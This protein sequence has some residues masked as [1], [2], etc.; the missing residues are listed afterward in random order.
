MNAS[1]RDEAA[2][3]L[4]AGLHVL[5]PREDGSKA[6]MSVN[7][8]WDTFKTEQPT[9]DQC[10]QWWGQSK[11]LGV[12]AAAGVECMDFDDL[13]AYREFK[14][15]A[16]ETNLDELVERIEQGYCD[17]TPGGGVR[18]LWRCPLANRSHNA[19]LARR[20]KRGDEKS[21]ERD[22]VKVLIELPDYAIVA[23]TGPEVHPAGKPYVRR[24]GGFDSVQEISVSERDALVELARSFDEMPAH[25][26]QPPDGPMA[27]TGTGRPGDEFNAR[28]SWSEILSGWKVSHSKGDTTYWTRPG[29]DWGVSASTN[30]AGTDLL[31]C[32]ST[33]TP[34]DPDRSYSKFSAYALL[35]HDGDFSAAAGKLAAD[36]YG[37]P[38]GVTV[39]T[40]PSL[41][42]VSFEKVE[43]AHYKMYAPGADTT[44]T[45]E[46]LRQDR[47]GL[48]CD[49]TV[50]CT[51][52]ATR[53][54][55][56]V[57]Y[58]GRY[59]LSSVT[60]RRTQAGYLGDMTDA[61]AV[62]WT[63]LL[64][65]LSRRV[66]K[67]ENAAPTYTLMHEIEIP[68][69]DLAQE[70]LGLRL[71]YG[72]PMILFGDGGTVK[73]YTALYIAGILALRGLSVAYYDWEL[74]GGEHR[75]RLRALFGDDN[76]PR[77]YYHRASRPLRDEAPA[78]KQMVR[79]CG[80]EYAVFD[81]MGFACAGPAE[82]HEA[83]KGYHEGLRSLGE[84]G[85]LHIAHTVK[86]LE[87]GSDRKPFGSA[88]WH[89]MARGTWNIK[90]GERDPDSA[91]LSLG[92]YNR[93]PLPDSSIAHPLELRF[94]FGPGSR[95]GAPNSVQVKT[96]DPGTDGKLRGE[97][98]TPTRV[99]HE[100]A[101]GP[102]M[103]VDLQENLP[104]VS[105]EALKKTLQRLR[106]DGKLEVVENDNRQQAYAL[107]G[108]EILV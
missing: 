85:S 21:H 82:T 15:W 16:A 43:D 84:I 32:W 23:P 101:G 60:A 77:I 104:D 8:Q 35:E 36:G 72:H 7:G 4:K 64:E 66:L 24:H 90:A 57:I 14:R 94:E 22:N 46:R 69:P 30:Y 71:P 99:L 52:P 92:L 83:A 6:P 20:P 12:V 18:W 53:G 1:L 107:A 38:Q 44:F 10:R 33:S 81:S 27:T 25:E 67:E 86:S 61:E 103:M 108:R 39:E 37:D 68:E 51:L 89:N 31:R 58:T 75:K 49:L 13:E 56:G 19:K 41:S 63:A 98:K 55:D 2:K 42:A 62:D 59:N 102:Q 28:A 76:P 11:G 100:L 70:V 45:V 93:K 17:D 106:S 96:Q 105:Y 65:A 91:G 87:A 3:A 80:I 54:E 5:P 50:H 79:D 78:L 73:S 29:K 97:L 48:V 34:F 47:N 74:T 40:E 9:A 95:D 26:Y 88:F